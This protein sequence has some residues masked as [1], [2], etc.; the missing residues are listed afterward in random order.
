MAEYFM[1]AIKNWFKDQWKRWA[2][3]TNDYFGNNDMPLEPNFLITPEDMQSVKNGVIIA[4]G[5]DINVEKRGSEP[6][7]FVTVSFVY[8]ISHRNLDKLT[9]LAQEVI[10]TFGNMFYSGD[11]C[12]TVTYNDGDSDFC[13]KAEGEIKLETTQLVGN[14]FTRAVAIDTQVEVF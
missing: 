8:I 14:Y 5:N 10:T 1:D 3:V 11:R 2:K 13:I 9:K 7:Y 12:Q 4:L 6:H